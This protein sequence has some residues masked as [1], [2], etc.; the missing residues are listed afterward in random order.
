[1]TG[2]FWWGLILYLVVVGMWDLRTRRVPN[3]LTLP[4]LGGVGIWRVWQ[5]VEGVR[6]R[7]EIPQELVSL[8]VYWAGTYILWALGAMGGGDAKLLMVLFG[9]FPTRQ[10]LILLLG[11]S[12][13]IMA[14]ALVWRYARRKRLRALLRGMMYRIAL[15]KLFP[16]REEV[17]MDGEPTAFLFCIAG[18]A[19]VILR[20]TGGV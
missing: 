15:M 9:I 3:G 16:S 11:I 14:L 1:M 5:A 2:I 17:E 20:L 10:F 12:G 18:I 13:G 6:V 8:L 19:M 7:G 4:A